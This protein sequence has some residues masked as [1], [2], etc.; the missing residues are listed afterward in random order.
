MVGNYLFFLLS[1]FRSMDLKLLRLTTL[2]QMYQ[3]ESAERGERIQ[4]LL[5]QKK[6]H[7]LLFAEWRRKHACKNLNREPSK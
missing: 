2:A 5:K 3:N 7:K 6:V 1:G 4:K